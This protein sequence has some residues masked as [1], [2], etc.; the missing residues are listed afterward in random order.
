MEFVPE[1]TLIRSEQTR[2][3][4][5]KKLVEFSPAES[6]TKISVIVEN[7]R[8][9]TKPTKTLQ[10]LRDVE[11][12]CGRSVSNGLQ[13]AHGCQVAHGQPQSISIT[14]ILGGL[15]S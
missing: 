7:K 5:D 13:E 3:Q 10:R 2:G 12:V 9:G 1:I 14:K 11:E 15:E 8:S 4:D 6:R